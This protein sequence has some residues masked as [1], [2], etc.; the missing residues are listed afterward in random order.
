MHKFRSCR[1]NIA[2]MIIFM[3]IKRAKNII[4][5]NFSQHK[6]V[7]MMQLKWTVYYRFTLS[8]TATQPPE[9]CLLT[10]YAWKL[11][12]LEGYLHTLLAV[13]SEQS[14]SK[15]HDVRRNATIH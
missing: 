15:Q 8:L 7:N 3:K 9:F 5:T 11:D 13:L 14:K 2:I 6:T 12:K 1:R 10:L 4:I